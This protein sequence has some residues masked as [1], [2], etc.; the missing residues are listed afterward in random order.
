MDNKLIKQILIIVFSFFLFYYI[1]Y[2]DDKKYN[3]KRTTIFNKYKNPLLITSFV[4]LIL[5][6]NLDTEILIP[7]LTGG[8]DKYENNI[9]HG[10]SK[11]NRDDFISFPPPF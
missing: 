9:Y 10:V 3:I 1:Q 5:N 4:G 2:R 7:K 8:N 11:F 6:I